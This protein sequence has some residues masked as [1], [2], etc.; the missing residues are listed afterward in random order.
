ML[1]LIFTFMMLVTE[2]LSGKPY[3]FLVTVQATNVTITG[4]TNVNRFVCGLERNGLNQSMQVRSIYESDTLRFDGLRLNF[5][6]VEFDCGLAVMNH[7]FQEFLMGDT[8]PEMYIDIDHMV[9]M[10]EGS[11]MEKVSVTTEIGIQLCGREKNYTLPRGYV[12]ELPENTIRLVSQEQLRFT[13][14]GMI[15]PTKFFGT[16]KVFDELDIAFEVELKVEAIK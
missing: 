9:I 8:Y 13:D 6:I 16:I 3:N 12:M 5:P 4:T 15:P 11:L 10:R 1:S 14:F 7:D 2:T